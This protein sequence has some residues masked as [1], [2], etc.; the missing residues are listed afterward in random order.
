M[1]MVNKTKWDSSVLRKI[2]GLSLHCERDRFPSPAAYSEYVKRLRVIVSTGKSE[3]GNVSGRGMYPS[4]SGAYGWRIRILISGKTIPPKP[5]EL[6][7]VFRHELLHNLGYRHGRMHHTGL[8]R[9]TDIKPED[10][11]FLSGISIP[12]ITE[13]ASPAKRDIRQ[14]RYL[15]AEKEVAHG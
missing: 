9:W 8:H 10:Y 3:A 13:P 4:P 1:R 11:S 7:F 5:I 2:F 6:S 15:R 14:S 12:L